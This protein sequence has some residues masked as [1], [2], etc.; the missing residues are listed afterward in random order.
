MRHARI[1]LCNEVL[2]PLSF[3]EQCALAARLGYVGLEVAPF[4]L[5]DDPARIPASSRAELRR[6][7]E[8]EGISITGLH[9]LLNV[10]AGLSLTSDDMATV[11]R[12]RAHMTA[13]IELCA[14]LGGRVLVHGSPQQR[15]LA[16]A[17]DPR[18]AR[19]AAVAHL[20]HAGE[21]AA[22]H[23]VTYCLEPLAPTLTDFVN[24]IDEAAEV[25][26][27]VASPACGTMI[28]TLAAWGGE[29]EEPDMLIRR[30][31]P[32]GHIRHVHLNDD[33]RR[34]PGQGARRFAPIM[35]ALHDLDYDGII[36]VEPFDY[37]PDGS[38]AAARAIGYL[39]GIC[40]EF[41][42]RT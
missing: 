35:R 15:R 37:F 6:A 14:D 2:A 10:P 13:M 17:R 11:S 42:S 39:Q 24:T 38:T 19:D 26:A 4:T 28:D 7:A 27:E 25:V 41:G 23:G 30:H 1:S 40:E 22:Q 16:D 21:A 34:A 31:L 29:A 9:W 20:R 33:N 18:R 8:N 3:E 36:A 5:S 12:T 32:A